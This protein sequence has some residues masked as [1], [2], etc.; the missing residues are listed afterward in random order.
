MFYCPSSL[1]FFAQLICSVHPIRF[2]GLLVMFLAVAI[3]PWAGTWCPQETVKKVIADFIADVCIAI[4]VKV[5]ASPTFRD[6]IGDIAENRIRDERLLDGI[7][8]IVIDNLRDG[9]LYVAAI[10][11]L[12]DAAQ[13][14]MKEKLSRAPSQKHVG[15]N[16]NGAPIA[17][18]FCGGEHTGPIAKSFCGRSS[19]D[20]GSSGEFGAASFAGVV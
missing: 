16:E 6:A 14:K 9:K 13:G 20:R 15:G 1:S 4:G 5:C 3:S 12:R 19:S 17:K 8:H 11:G 18:S 10:Q 7:R 2:V